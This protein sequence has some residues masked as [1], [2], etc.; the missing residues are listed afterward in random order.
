MPGG[1][2]GTTYVH[3][4]VV[5]RAQALLETGRNDFGE[6]PEEHDT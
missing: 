3:Q 5:D 2:D 6:L 4:G 1:L